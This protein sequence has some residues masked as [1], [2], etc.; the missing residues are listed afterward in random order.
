[1]KLAKRTLR[2]LGYNVIKIA[3]NTDPWARRI[4]LIRREAVDLVIDVGAHTGGFGAALLR[5]GYKGRLLSFEPQ[6]T[7]L[8]ALYQ[9]AAMQPRWS[10]EPVAL[11]SDDGIRT[12]YISSRSSTSSLS[13]MTE[14]AQTAA[15]VSKMIPV[16]VAVRRLDSFIDKHKLDDRKIYLKCDV[17]G[18]EEEVIMGSLSVLQN[19]K[20][21][22]VELSIAPVY[23]T[24]WDLTKAM[25]WFEL[26]NFEPWSIEAGFADPH[27]GR[28]MQVDGVF[29]RI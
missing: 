24:Q 25:K 6:A 23:K 3:P 19:V 26:N 2:A 9:K 5:A 16:K 20:C 4:A 22:E 17:Q 28:V 8:K 27:T 13:E 29:R 7:A 18:A 14:P 10:V 21:V 1:M 11:A 12:F 15:A